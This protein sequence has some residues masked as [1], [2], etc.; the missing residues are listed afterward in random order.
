MSLEKKDEP[1]A[2]G[3]LPFPRGSVF[4]YDIVD[5]QSARKRV[6]KINKAKQGCPTDRPCVPE[7]RRASV[8][9]Y[10]TNLN[11]PACLKHGLLPYHGMAKVA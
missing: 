7:M 2:T 9:F 4:M 10:R 11:I 6:V 3:F 5:I 8:L 1:G